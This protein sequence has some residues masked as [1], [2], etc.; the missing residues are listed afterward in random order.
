MYAILYTPV[1]GLTGWEWFWVAVAG[2]FDIIHWAAGV[3]CG[4]HPAQPAPGR[5]SRIGFTRFG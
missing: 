4:R 1:I 3:G 5:R 2:L